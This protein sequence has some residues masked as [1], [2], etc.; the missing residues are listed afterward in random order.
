MLVTLFPIVTVVSLQQNEN[1]LSPIF[2]APFP[3]TTDP[4]KVHR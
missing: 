2:V 1:A 3:I 4:S